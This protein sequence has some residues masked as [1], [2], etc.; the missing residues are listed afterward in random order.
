MK[1][2][3]TISDHRIATLDGLR[4]IAILAVVILHL[5]CDRLAVEYF[6]VSLV[7][8]RLLSFQARG[9]DLFFVISGFLI[10][11]I[12]VRHG[13]GGGVV[14]PFYLRRI[15]RILPLYYLLLLVALFIGAF[16]STPGWAYPL[17][18]HNFYWAFGYSFGSILGP[19]WSLAVEEQ[20]YL[21][22]PWCH[23]FFGKFLPALVLGALVL[24]LLVKTVGAENHWF[25]RPRFFTLNCMGGILFGL[26]AAWA[27]HTT[28]LVTWMRQN[29]TRASA[30]VG[31]SS[32]LGFVGAIGGLSS[33]WWLLADA[34]LGFTFSLL[35]IHVTIFRCRPLELRWLRL[36]GRNC[37]FIYLFHIPV[38]ELLTWT[39]RPPLDELYPFAFF[40]TVLTV[41]L[42]VFSM[43]YL[44][45][46]LIQFASRW[47]YTA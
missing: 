23:R 20:F 47:K 38:F 33:W 12:F 3:P 13:A 22:Y 46:P 34:I 7:T 43:R 40:A 36:L 44:E 45:A 14:K 8:A 11:G 37:Y 2:T 29:A 17:F 9:V 15:F 10:G 35:V 31:L 26:L 41:V 6:D 1:L 30:L 25:E 4:G 18:L 16:G 42:S 24:T 27:Y 28:S 21:L 5:F 19:A 32:G 39:L